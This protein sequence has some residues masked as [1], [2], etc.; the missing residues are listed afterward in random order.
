MTS[1]EILKESDNWRKRTQEFLLIKIGP[2]IAK[3]GQTGVDCGLRSSIEQSFG[4]LVAELAL[5]CQPSANRCNTVESDRAG[6]S[7]QLFGLLE[8]VGRAEKS[9]KPKS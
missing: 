2:R 8:S 4:K 3:L 6:G 1:T 7:I 5:P 9:C